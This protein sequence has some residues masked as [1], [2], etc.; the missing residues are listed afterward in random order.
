MNPNQPNGNG[1]NSPNNNDKQP[2]RNIWMPLIITIGIILAII[3]AF[4][5]EAGSSGQTLRI[6]RRPRRGERADRL[7]ARTLL[8]SVFAPTALST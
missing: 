1:N 7:Q 4:P 2:R 6:M 3:L 8:V 5:T